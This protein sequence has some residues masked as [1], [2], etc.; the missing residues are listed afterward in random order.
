MD[1]NPVVAG[2]FYPGSR[3]ALENEVKKFLN[4]EAKPAKAM[5][6]IAPHAGYVYSGAVAGAVFGS[7]EVPKRCIV[8]SPNHT[9]M[10]ARAAVWPRGSWSIPTGK[11]PVDEAK[12]KITEDL[13]TE[14]SDQAF[15]A[16]I[17]ELRSKAKIT[18]K[19]VRGGE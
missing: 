7:I 12:R 14:K 17:E 8:L 4:V 16:W 1:R 2:Q 5:A 15:Q 11:I 10:G 9:G 13:K 6:A 3:T 19:D 18:I